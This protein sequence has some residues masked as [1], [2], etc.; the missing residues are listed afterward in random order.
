MIK[1][2][3]W[4]EK[5]KP[6]ALHMSKGAAKFRMSDLFSLGIPWPIPWQ[7]V[8]FFFAINWTMDRVPYILN[9]YTTRDIIFVV[10]TWQEFAWDTLSYT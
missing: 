8:D 2:E 9:R 5:M 7:S 10:C 1:C 6:D 4:T 3:S